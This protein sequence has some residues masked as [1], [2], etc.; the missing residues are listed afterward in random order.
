MVPGLMNSKQ[1]T[2]NDL[3]VLTEVS[4]LLTLTDLDRVL[5]QVIHLAGKA[6]GASQTSLFLQE[7]QH[8]DWEHLITMRD[9]PPE[10]SVTVVSRV[11]EEGLAGW[12]ARHQEGAIIEDTADDPRWI[13]FPDDTIPARSALCVPFIYNERVIAI[14]TLVHEEPGHFQAY[15]LRL[16]TIIT[17]QAAIAIRNVQLFS[18]LKAQRRHLEGVLHSITDAL[19]VL[20]DAGRVMLINPA[21]GTLL[22]VNGEAD[23]KGRSLTEF[24][25]V[26]KVFEPVVE[27]VQADLTDNE[28]WSFETRSERR[29]R[30][31]QVTMA[32]W[33]NPERDE[34]GYV[35]VMHN[36]TRLHD[37]SRF[38]DE[39]L[40]VASHD[41]RSPLALISGYA[42]MVSM[43]TPDPTSPVHEYVQII[44]QSVEKM[45]G[46][47]EDLLRV[48]RVRSSPLELHE[49]VDLAALVK[50]V[51]VNARPFASARH[52]TFDSEIDLQDVPR[53]SADSVLLRQAMEN[54]INNAIKYTQEEG[55]VTVRAYYDAD[56]FHFSVEDTGIGIPEEHQSYVFESFYRVRQPGNGTSQ[57]KSSGLGLSLVKNVIARHHGEIWVNSTVGEGSRFGFWLPLKDRS[58]DEQQAACIP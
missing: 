43:D 27:I 33:D 34:R 45:G 9:L 42:D 55:R 2:F 38:K 24:I 52:L 1:P 35:I 3:E 12:V 6:V 46:L 53:I 13:T 31:Y 15:H 4:Q 47:V 40:R 48:E 51:L 26:D 37:L 29:Q 22:Q 10:Q 23:A 32:L 44:K 49:Q 17:N 57:P 28:R 25:M 14:V 50:V 8:I 7:G 11:M 16:L 5:Q 36:V 30:D 19:L 21:A 41:L 56:K 20:D 18:N 39:M 58:A 54:L